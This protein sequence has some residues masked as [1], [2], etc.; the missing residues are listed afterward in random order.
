MHVVDDD[1]DVPD[2]AATRDHVLRHVVT[3]ARVLRDAGA[4]VPATASI[5]ATRALVELGFGDKEQVRA[6]LRATLLSRPDDFDAFDQLFPG[7]WRRL[8][9]GAEAGGGTPGPGA[10]S[11]VGGLPSFEDG[12]PADEPTPDADSGDDGPGEADDVEEI[13]ARLAARSADDG[14]DETGEGATA[15]TYSPAGSPEPVGLHPGALREDDRLEAAVGRLGAGLAGL[16]GRRWAAG[17]DRIDARRALRRSFG[18]GGAVLSL[19]E[20]ERART[21]V[22]A[23]LLVDVSRSVLDTIDRGFLVRFLRAAASTWRSTRIVFFDTEAR[24]VTAHFD[25]DTPAAA[26]AALERAE[27]EWGGGTRIGHA[28]ETVRRDHPDAVD[29]DTVVLVVSDG[30]EVGEVDVLEDGMAWLS[31]RAAG[32]LWLNP[33]AVSPDYEPTCRGMAAALPYVDGLFAFA[34]VAD[35]EEIARQLARHRGGRGLGY[36]H[37]P[38]RRADT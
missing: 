35:A 21:A 34:S 24:E 31:G 6:G 13:E 12:G 33:L 29:R 18:T 17:E 16:R 23:L 10:E 11:P 28:V 5:E 22:R 14:A 26:M 38:R 20:R 25:T 15:S 2:F 4:Q 1:G 3:F 27:A 32:V 36:E 30:L 19:P 9:D 8:T 37:D 7:F